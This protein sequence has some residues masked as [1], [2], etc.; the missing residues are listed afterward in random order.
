MAHGNSSGRDGDNRRIRF[1][2]PRGR[3][4]RYKWAMQ[5]HHSIQ[6]Q[7]DWLNLAT[8]LFNADENDILLNSTEK[9]NVLSLLANK[10]PDSCISSYDR[11]V[12]SCRIVDTVR[13]M[14]AGKLPLIETNVYTALLRYSMEPPAAWIEV[15]AI[16]ERLEVLRYLERCAK[17]EEK[18][19]P[20][21]MRDAMPKTA[22]MVKVQ[23]RDDDPGATTQCPTLTDDPGASTLNKLDKS[24]AQQW[25][26]AVLSVITPTPP[27]KKRKAAAEPP[28]QR[29]ATP[30]KKRK[31]SLKKTATPKKMTGQPVVGGSS[32]K[33]NSTN[34]VQDQTGSPTSSLRRARRNPSAAIESLAGSLDAVLLA[35]IF[36][37]TEVLVQVAR[38]DDACVRRVALSSFIVD[39]QKAGWGD[40][41]KSAAQLIKDE[42]RASRE[43]LA[44]MIVSG[45]YQRM[46]EALDK[47]VE[48]TKTD[49]G[50]GP[51]S[52]R[53]GPRILFRSG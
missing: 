44:R 28:S 12:G 8:K 6:W 53:R 10:I 30:T 34:Q 27:S 36:K 22:V 16:M 26:Q 2:Q 38:Y 19:S 48:Q 43:F 17:G 9:N 15:D 46:N 51:A 21:G 49:R 40:L 4:G 14:M 32:I 47:D 1:I 42:N 35:N 41:E 50:G 25:T 29:N 18:Y 20:E 24:A 39:L 13:K 33:H 5:P 45:S 37:A 52:G 11:A 3:G 31:V 7:K 23:L